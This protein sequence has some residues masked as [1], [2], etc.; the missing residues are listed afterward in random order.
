MTRKY[1]GTGLGL[2]ICQQL[3]T[4]MDGEIGVVSAPGNGSTFWFTIRVEKQEGAPGADGSTKAALAGARVLIVDDSATYRHILDCCLSSQKME[5]VC[6]ASGSEALEILKWTEANKPF[7]LAII[8]MDMPEMDGLALARAIHSW[9]RAERIRVVILTS[10]GEILSGESDGSV[11]ACLVKPVKQSSLP[12]CL[13]RVMANHPLEAGIAGESAL[14]PHV[15]EPLREV[16]ILLAED[17]PINRIIV[18]AQLK[19]LGYTA[20]VASNGLE[21]LQLQRQTP[22]EI[23]LMDCQMPEMDGY[24]TTRCLRA[25][26]NG[27]SRPYIVALT[28]HTTD[29]ASAKCFE[30]GMNDYISKP[31]RFAAFA[32]VLAKA[33][34]AVTATDDA[35][36]P[37]GG[38]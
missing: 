29:E 2:A 6:A 13:A 28:A 12:G 20:S 23:I 21:V 14:F 3:V 22:F 32:T 30:A 24:E 27:S 8:D 31:V 35:D 5:T 9:P 38:V 10:L 16:R 37:T 7:Q 34:S 18:V 25:R 26:G 11:D 4:M 19:Q 1:G 36:S 17:N 15:P 33:I